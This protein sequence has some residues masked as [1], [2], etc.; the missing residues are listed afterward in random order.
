V[1]LNT[2]LQHET[3]SYNGGLSPRIPNLGT[4]WKGVFRF[5][6]VKF[7]FQ[8]ATCTH[9]GRVWTY[10]VQPRRAPLQGQTVFLLPTGIRWELQSIL[11]KHRRQECPYF[12][13]TTLKL[14]G[15]RF[16]LSVHFHKTTQNII[17]RMS[18]LLWQ[19]GTSDI[20]DSF[21]GP[22]GKITI[23]ITQYRLKYCVV[24]CN[25]HVCHWILW[26]L[27]AIWTPL[28]SKA[29]SGRQKSSAMKALRSFN[30][31]KYFH[32][33]HGVISP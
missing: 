25:V 22:P 19:R 28:L 17:S 15:I 2:P 16:H 9:L 27:A 30:V 12:C 4:R 7:Y 11:S 24:L 31:T 21:A 20:L 1:P 5:M 26:P 8:R 29:N 3:K 6:I 32:I 14:N 33:R 18:K 13:Y 10:M 23:N